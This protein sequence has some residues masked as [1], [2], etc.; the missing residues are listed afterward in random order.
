MVLC[1][2]F[3][4]IWIIITSSIALRHWNDTIICMVSVLS[5]YVYA[6]K[7]EFFFSSLSFLIDFKI[8]YYYKNHHLIETST[9]GRKGLRI[10]GIDFDNNGDT[11]LLKMKHFDDV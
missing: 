5:N 2:N 3:F 11:C 7:S 10:N 6:I 4:N 1:N 9:N 8:I